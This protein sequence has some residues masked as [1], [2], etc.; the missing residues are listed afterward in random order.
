MRAAV[1]ALTLLAPVAAAAATP[2]DLLAAVR[3]GELA[4]VKAALDAGVPVDAPFRYERTA[5]SFA[6]DRGNLEIVRLLLDRGADPNK[7]D[8]F[9]SATAMT[10]AIS[11]GNAAMA[12]LLVERGA[13]ADPE[14]LQAGAR[15]GNAELVALA[16]EKAKPTADDL[17]VAL[18]EA[19]QR[20]H[21]AVAEQ[22]TQSGA[23]PPQPADFVVDAA[24]LAGYAGLYRNETGGEMRFEL[25]EGKLVCLT[26]NAP[27]LV[28]GAVDTVT[29]RNPERPRPKLVFTPGEGK[30]SS[31]TMDFGSRQVGYRRAFEEAPKEKP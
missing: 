8:T 10:W 18:F 28:L 29:F 9:Y 16:L 1:L 2:D 22:L 24:T 6:A 20:K 3:K 12:R 17:S 5:L 26:C 14:L 30:A 7:K 31:L 19:Q 25:A 21:A 4:G 11:K 23:K 15:D 27:R 13:P